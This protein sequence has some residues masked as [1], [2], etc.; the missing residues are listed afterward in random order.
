MGSYIKNIVL[1]KHSVTCVSP[2]FLLFL[3]LCILSEFL[4][5]NDLMVYRLLKAN[6]KDLGCSCHILSQ[7]EHCPRPWTSTP[8]DR[9]LAV[10]Y[11]TVA[12]T[13]LLPSFQAGESC[14]QIMPAIWEP[15]CDLPPA[16]LKMSHFLLFTLIKD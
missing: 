15:V 3:S 5:K 12:Y 11:V 1:N 13:N 14:F 4:P 6:S 10:L 2:H 8:A 7:Y 16:L 9:F